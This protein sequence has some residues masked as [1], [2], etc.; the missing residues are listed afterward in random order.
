MK[1]E[2]I[3]S[4]NVQKNDYS[5][6]WA[7]RTRRQDKKNYTVNDAAIKKRFDF[8]EDEEI[9]VRMKEYGK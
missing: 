8:A 4:S 6:F 3:S 9:Q 2:K 5:Y 7:N 1:K